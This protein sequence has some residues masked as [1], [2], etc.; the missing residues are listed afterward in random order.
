MSGRQNCK[1]AEPKDSIFHSSLTLKQ[2][3]CCLSD[4]VQATI[5]RATTQYESVKAD[6]IQVLLNSLSCMAKVQTSSSKRASHFGHKKKVPLGVTDLIMLVAE[7]CV[8]L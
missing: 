3:D 4:V 6:F 2:I 5:S 1:V 8:T 7:D